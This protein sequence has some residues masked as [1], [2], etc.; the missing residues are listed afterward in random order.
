MTTAARSIVGCSL[1]AGTVAVR[2]TQCSTRFFEPLRPFIKSFWRVAFESDRR[3]FATISVFGTEYTRSAIRKRRCPAGPAFVRGRR[4][5]NSALRLPL[6]SA[7]IARAEKKREHRRPPIPSKTV[8]HHPA[9]V[10]A[11]GALQVVHNALKFLPIHQSDM[12]FNALNRTD[13]F[14]FR[15]GPCS[16]FF[17]SPGCCRDLGLGHAPKWSQ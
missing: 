7:T 9:F 6:D 12:P 4:K 15:N 13:R 8:Q 3:C 11:K 5:N 10:R 2:A 17:R 14:E 16:D 1:P